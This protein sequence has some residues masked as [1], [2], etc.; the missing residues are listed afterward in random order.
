MDVFIEELVEKK[1]EKKDHVIAVLLALGAVMLSFIVL[2]LVIILPTVSMALG[3]VIAMFW[4]LLVILIWYYAYKFYSKLSIEYEYSVINS[5]LDID[6]IMSK[7]SRTRV[8]S[9]DIKDASYMACIDDDE[10]N[11][12]YVNPPQGIKILNYSAMSENGYTYFIDC[13]VGGKRTIV[14]FQPSSKMV[15]ALW[16]YNP[17]AIKKYNS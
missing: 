14:L 7:K 9:L 15:E 16:K 8:L 4:P 17:K 6:K 10:N 11:D 1:K 12:L 2:A 13:S 5:N 3:H